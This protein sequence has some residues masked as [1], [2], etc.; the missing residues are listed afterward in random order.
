VPDVTEIREPNFSLDLPGEW[1]QAPSSADETLVFGQIGGPASVSVT[2]L[3]VRPMFEIADGLRMLEDYMSHRQ[4][5]EA[6]PELALGHTDPIAEQLGDSFEGRW[7][8]V[9]RTDG[10]LIEH[11]VLLVN[12]L[13]ADF[14]YEAAGVEAAAFAEQAALTLGSASASE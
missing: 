11:R 12:V 8:S 3:R 7:S 13:L 9:G 10:R 6:G 1:E 4:T 14:A 2:L 5:F